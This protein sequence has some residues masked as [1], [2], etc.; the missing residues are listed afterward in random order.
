V[1]F[2]EAMTGVDAADF[3]L[4]AAGV[5]SA[6]ITDVSGGPQTYT[7]SVN[8][9]S[10]DGTLRLD[11]LDDDSI[12][13]ASSVPLG[14]AGLG[15]GGFNNGEMYVVRPTTQTFTSQG[16][17]DGWI[18]ESEQW[19]REGG[20][21]NSAASLL[22]I[23]DD[24]QNRQYLSILHFNTDSLPD[25]SIVISAKLQ[26]KRH[27]LIGTNPFYTHT[28]FRVDQSKPRFGTGIALQLM[29]FNA[30]PSFPYQVAFFEP[31]PVN[32][33]YSAVL[34]SYGNA[35]LNLTGPTQFRLRFVREQNLDGDADM[36]K[37]YSGDAP[38]IGNR[39]ALV[40]EY[41]LP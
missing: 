30:T 14:E 19:S 22:N 2:S 3:I 15:N 39:P 35:N 8:T 28:Y 34:T 13:N 12:L 26:L 9:G 33:W 25:D 29:D 18:L 23:G 41:Y 20:T 11:V 27:S 1:T 5:T 31:V 10:D 4:T 32:N 6:S 38:A 21:L 7:V 37:F 17:Q 36:L 40:V 24:A 16:A